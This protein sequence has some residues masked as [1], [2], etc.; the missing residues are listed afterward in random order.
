MSDAQHGDIQIIL[1]TYGRPIPTM[2]HSHCR[3]DHS[4]D[5]SGK[6]LGLAGQRPKLNTVLPPFKHLPEDTIFYPRCASVFPMIQEINAFLCCMGSEAPV[7]PRSH[8]NLLKCARAKL[9]QCDVIYSY[10]RMCSG[11]K[12]PACPG[13]QTS[14]SLTPAQPQP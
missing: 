8:W 3:L 2:S 6:V 4:P 9:C 5:P 10:L 12:N 14:I 1:S 13:S 7:R 11:L